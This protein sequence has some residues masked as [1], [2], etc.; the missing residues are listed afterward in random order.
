MNRSPQSY[1]TLSQLAGSFGLPQR[2]VEK[3]RGE[4]AAENLV[5]FCALLPRVTKRTPVI[6]APNSLIAN[7]ARYFGN[8]HP[9]AFVGLQIAALP[10]GN[11]GRFDE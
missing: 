11:D 8:R 2:G 9:S 10:Y 5:N 3:R 6:I 7:A 4:R 1:G